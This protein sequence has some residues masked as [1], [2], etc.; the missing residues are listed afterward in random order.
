MLRHAHQI[1][2]NRL[3]VCGINPKHHVLDNECSEE[4]KEAIKDNKMTYQLVPPDD[5][6]RNVSERLIQTAK[7]HIVSVLCGA[8]P[9]FPMHLWDFLIPQMEIQLNLQ[10]QFRTV[11]KVSAYAQLYGPYDFNAHLPAP[12]GTAVGT[13]SS[14]PRGQ[15]GACAPFWDGT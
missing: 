11:P 14:Q 5:H 15:V 7:S 10:R 2:I 4:F 6:Q 9:N 12:L 1:L 3:K 13:T 8:D